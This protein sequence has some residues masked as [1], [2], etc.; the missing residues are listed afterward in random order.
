MRCRLKK[1]S[2]GV[3]A[4]Y[5]AWNSDGNFAE[6]RTTGRACLRR[7]GCAEGGTMIKRTARS[8]R[9]IVEG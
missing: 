9:L 2:D 8:M 5:P 1:E 6:N 7:T 3:W 4:V